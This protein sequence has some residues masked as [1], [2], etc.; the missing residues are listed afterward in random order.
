MRQS[1]RVNGK[2]R[3]VELS[4]A[5]GIAL[6]PRVQ[7]DPGQ[8]IEIRLRFHLTPGEY[9]FL[10][11][12]GGGTHAGRTLA[13][14]QFGFDVDE[15]GR[16]HVTTGA[17]ALGRER[18]PRR[19]G[20]VCGNVMLQDGSPAANARVFLWPVPMAKEMPRAA[21]SELAD[22]EGR[23]RLESVLEGKYVLSAQLRGAG[24]TMVG[25]LGRIQPGGW[26]GARRAGF[27]RGLLQFRD[28]APATRLHGSRAH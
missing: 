26:R 18:P 13:S 4:L 24:V 7:L 15:A 14:N 3:T 1:C 5:P 20:S 17:A 25:R 11:G 19:I 28:L 12:Y 10:A 2:E 27:L 9:E 21:N 22:G 6:A 8:S 23:F 16:A